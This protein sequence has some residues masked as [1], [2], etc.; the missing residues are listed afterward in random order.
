MA[1]APDDNDAAISTSSTAFKS[2]FKVGHFRLAFATLD[3]EPMK[4]VSQAGRWAG[5]RRRA[6]GSWVVERREA[7]ERRGGR[8]RR[9]KEGDKTRT[10]AVLS[11]SCS[12]R[13]LPHSA[14]SSRN[15]SLKRDIALLLGRVSLC[16]FFFFSSWVDSV[17]V[18][19]VSSVYWDDDKFS[20]LLSRPCELEW[21]GKALRW[22][23][24]LVERDTR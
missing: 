12:S 15:S 6:P 3:E 13:P 14:L 23:G 2:D 5:G 22:C 4:E 20:F 17:A 8:R 11:L 19:K 7:G 9:G 18:F 16:L 24:R 10:D 1:G 21:K